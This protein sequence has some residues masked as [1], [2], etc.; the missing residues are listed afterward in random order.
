VS[1]PTVAS[2]SSLSAEPQEIRR[3]NLFE[4]IVHWEVTITFIALM[5][6][7]MALAYPRLAWL[8]S[9]FGGG[10]TMRAAHPW[11]GIAFTVGVL[12]MLIVWAK[13]MLLERG[14]RQWVRRLRVY[15]REGHN[16]LDTGRFNAGQ[17]GYF[18]FVVILS[19]LLLLTGLPLWH[20][21]L[22][23]TRWREWAR[24]LHHACYLLMLAG[25]I[26]HVFMSTVF[27]PG[28]MS[29]MTT[30]KVTRRWAA[31]HHSRWYRDQTSEDQ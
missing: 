16:G 7:G 15:T 5:L 31:W 4:R 6:S 18:W 3:Y 14:D 25:F 12:A 17:K 11:I 24:L 2:D 1:S 29:S 10:Q 27:L 28:T 8:S 22:L 20:T 26:V 13:P 9:L 19:V 21:S 30:G 23:G